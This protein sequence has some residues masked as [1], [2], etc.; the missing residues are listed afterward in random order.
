MSSFDV[1]ELL[2]KPLTALN[3]EEWEALCD[4]CGLCCLEKLEDHEQD[5]IW[6]T[7]VPCRLLDPETG[8]CRDYDNRRKKVPD[9]L[10]VDPYQEKNRKILPETCAYRRRYENREL[11]DWHPLLTGDPRSVYRAG[12]SVVSLAVKWRPGI[13]IEDYI[14]EENS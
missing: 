11:P 14:I 7:R 12:K 1:K 6:Y 2:E 5:V 10:S 4:R 8:L 13:K 3:P 9:C